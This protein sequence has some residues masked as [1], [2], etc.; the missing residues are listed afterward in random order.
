MVT[1]ELPA[2]AIEFCE[3]QMKLNRHDGK[4]DKKQ[5]QSVIQREGYLEQQAYSDA[6][7]V[8][9]EVSD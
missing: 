3:C 9:F 1:S 2:F 4:Q 5:K 8:I 7:V 6:V